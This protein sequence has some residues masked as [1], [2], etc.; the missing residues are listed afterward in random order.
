M[1]EEFSTIKPDILRRWERYMQDLGLSESAYDVEVRVVSDPSKSYTFGII[2]NEYRFSRP[3][4]PVECGLCQAVEEIREDW[5][6]NLAPEYNVPGFEIIPNIFPPLRGASLAITSGTGKDELPMAS[7]INLGNFAADMFKLRE[8]ADLC[9]FQL[10][11]N[12]PGFGSSIPQHEHWH[13]TDFGF[14]YDKV[15]QMYGFDAESKVEFSGTESFMPAFPFAHVI[16]GRNN[17]RGIKGFLE[18]IGEDLGEVP[19]AIAEGKKGYLVTLAKNFEKSIGSGETA[20]HMVVKTREE[21]EMANYDSCM[22][23]LGNKLYSK[24]EL[25]LTKYL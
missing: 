16:F 10:Y 13:L 7:T 5:E 4:L 11:H 9:G 2:L 6:R 22:K 19:H 21:F 15:G 23:T 12:S 17:T 14:A 24:E 18:R 20:G 25:D 8:F 3:Q 1:R